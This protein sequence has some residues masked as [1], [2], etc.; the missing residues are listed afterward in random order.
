MSVGPGSALS[1]TLERNRASVFVSEAL[2]TRP[3]ETR[4]RAVSFS[5]P[6]PAREGWGAIEGRLAGF[7]A[8]A[9]DLPDGEKLVSLALD[10]ATAAVLSSGGDVESVHWHGGIPFEETLSTKA[11]RLTFLHYGEGERSFVAQV[12]PSGTAGSVLS[13]GEPF[14]EELARAGTYRLEVAAGRSSRRV[15]VSGAAE[16]ATFVGASGR[17][18]RGSELPI[19]D[20][21]G[22]LLLHHRPG[23][24]VTWI[25]SDE[26]RVSDTTSVDPIDIALPARPSLSGSVSRFRL[27][28]SEPVV[29]HLRT[30]TPVATLINDELRFHPDGATVATFLPRGTSEIEIRA[31]GGGVLSGEAEMTTSAVLAIGEGLGPEVL[32]P[33]GSTRVFSFEVSRAGAVGVGVRATTDVVSTTLL[34]ESGRT[35]GR[36][37]VQMHEL[38]PGRYLLAIESPSDAPAVTARPAVA[39]IAPPSTGPPSEVIRRYIESGNPR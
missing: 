13:E 24:V 2:G 33:A 36:G 16:D 12:L 17:V 4:V 3:V 10:E 25:E 27:A 5:K 32:L 29:F 7:E 6:E 20:E 22:Y 39:G 18:L 26:T 14:Q 21:S 15:R 31:I 8:R 28:L 19:E 37:V 38:S 34:D 35:L 23:T 11:S 9:F 30:T 1:A